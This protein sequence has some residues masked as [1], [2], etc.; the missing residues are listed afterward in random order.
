MQVSTKVSI[1]FSVVILA[2]V[3]FKESTMLGKLVG[4][5]FLNLIKKAEFIGYLLPFF[6]L[7][8][9]PLIEC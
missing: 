6:V 1:G 9:S 2:G 4:N 5:L 8:N 7:F 3:F